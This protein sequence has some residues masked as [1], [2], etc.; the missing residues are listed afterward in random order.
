MSAENLLLQY[1]TTQLIA[2]I[3][4]TNS[5]SFAIAGFIIYTVQQLFHY[6]GTLVFSIEFAV[7]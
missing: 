1:F 7:L 4:L 3:V 5:F 2:K 6:N